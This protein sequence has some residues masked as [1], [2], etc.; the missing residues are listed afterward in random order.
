MTA[1]LAFTL[2]SLF[3]AQGGRGQRPGGAPPQQQTPAVDAAKPAAEPAKPLTEETPVITKH[4]IQANGKTLSY[5][6]TT[7]MMPIKNQQGE[8]EANMFFVA[9][10]LDGVSDIS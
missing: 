3:L 4:Q 1:S 5:T 7:G 8:I 2:L 6:A 9:Y 10:T